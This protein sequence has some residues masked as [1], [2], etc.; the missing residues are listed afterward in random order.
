MPNLSKTFFRVASP[1]VGIA[2]PCLAFQVVTNTAFSPTTKT[3]PTKV[4][5]TD[6]SVSP[7]LVAD[8]SICGDFYCSEVLNFIDP[9]TSVASATLQPTPQVASPAVNAIQVGQWQ[10]SSWQPTA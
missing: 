8:G 7:Q 10:G 4:S 3:I 6:S 1:I 5:K 2:L 9:A